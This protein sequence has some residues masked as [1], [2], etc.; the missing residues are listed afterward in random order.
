MKLDSLVAV[1][2]KVKARFDEE[3]N[4]V[5]ARKMRAA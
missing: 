3:N 2:M 1:F 4:L 5:W